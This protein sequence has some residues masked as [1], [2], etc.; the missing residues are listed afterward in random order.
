MKKLFFILLLF[1]IACDKQGD[2]RLEQERNNAR[3]VKELQ[4]KTPLSES[5]IEE[6]GEML[7]LMGRGDE[8]L[9]T[10]VDVLKKESLS[11]MSL[12]G[13]NRDEIKE[14]TLLYFLN[15]VNGG[16]AILDARND[17]DPIIA[18][19]ERGAM[20]AE[21]FQGKDSMNFINHLI[22]SYILDENRPEEVDDD[23][24]APVTKASPPAGNW[25]V[26]EQYGPLLRTKWHQGAPFNE[27]FSNM[28][29][30]CTSLAMAQVVA[31]KQFPKLNQFPYSNLI[32][33]WS[34][35]S[36]KPEPTTP[37][38]WKF[39][40]HYLRS[41][42]DRCGTEFDEEKGGG[43]SDK[44]LARAMRTLKYNSVMIRPYAIS[45]IKNMISLNKPVFISGYRMQKGREVGHNW[46]IDGYRKYKKGASVRNYV[47]CVIGWQDYAAFD[48]WYRSGLFDPY[49]R[50]VIN[51]SDAPN[52][53]KSL[54]LI[55]YAN[56]N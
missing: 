2:M 24:R 52:R 51:D 56:P 15:F 48:G 17:D 9:S 44:K 5:T 21:A 11:T 23:L 29:V 42:S 10:T 45:T 47:N 40:K 34:Q 35:I 1:F 4:A 31:Y 38:E 14:D 53:Y 20:N 13:M 22:M 8:L 3:I 55:T 7:E 19:T 25:K 16:Y 43:S 39:L 30:G 12:C 54:N 41:I 6:L 50:E 28:L 36:S 46:I 32:S 27:L 33:N 49:N 26:A 18:I 37:D